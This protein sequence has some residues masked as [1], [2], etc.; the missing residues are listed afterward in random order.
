MKISLVIL[1]S[2]TPDTCPLGISY[3]AAVLKKQRYD[4][5]TYDYN[6]QL[7]NKCKSQTSED[8]WSS[9]KYTKWCWEDEFYEET[10]PLLEP[11]LNECIDELVESEP[12]VVGFSTFDT[13]ILCT[14]YVA[15][16]IKKRNPEIKIVLG[17]PGAY[18]TNISQ[19]LEDGTVDYG[20]FGEGEVTMQNLMQYIDT[21]EGIP[22]DM[23]GLF[24]KGKDN[25]AVKNT[26]T[27]NMDIS[28]LPMPDFS[29]FDL[30]QY[31][32][33]CLPLM[34]SRG[35]VA[36]CSFCG[37]VRFW[38]KFRMR[39]AEHIMKEFDNG[40]Q[41]YGIA[42]FAVNDS[43][44]NG[45]MRIL[46]ELV[47]LLLI[48]KKDFGG[49][50]FARR[51]K[52][53]YHWGGYSRVDKRLTPEFLAKLKDAGCMHLSFGVESGSQ[54]VLDL[55]QK[56]ATVEEAYRTIRETGKAGINVILNI[57]IGYPNE[58]LIDFAKTVKMVYDNRKYIAVVCTG[59]T[60]GIH[61]D[62]PLYEHPEH[63][64]IK[65]DPRG[66]PLCD[67][68]GNWVSIDGKSTAR[69]RRRR[70]NLFRWFLNL[71]DQR[72]SPDGLSLPRYGGQ[73]LTNLLIHQPWRKI[74]LFF[75]GIGFLLGLGKVKDPIYKKVP[76]VK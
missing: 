72:W 38:Y 54:R 61:V 43:L 21:G 32:Q 30:T 46:S 66:G 47:D 7:W 58:R 2:W 70:M 53:E 6:V 55:M 24:I 59:E 49:P 50:G 62:T 37:E 26:P 75:L 67:E 3:I 73:S 10:L 19:D 71:A 45:N 65:A 63:F 76:V 57:I 9:G 35:C 4:V 60:L 12:D 22:H 13:S 40:F 52:Q 18:L 33:M 1:P 68:H 23:T 51:N 48:R 44:I 36:Q 25:K 69:L 39:P 5:K 42:Q 34:M 17:G 28:K 29:D 8:L 15:Q 56:N 11:H 27:P 20:V 64:G 31:G 16:G 14:R 41:K 74:S